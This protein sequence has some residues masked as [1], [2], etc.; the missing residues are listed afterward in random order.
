M[1]AMMTNSTAYSVDRH[2]EAYTIG[3]HRERLQREKAEL[4]QEVSDLIDRMADLQDDFNTDETPTE[5]H[6]RVVEME[7][8]AQQFRAKNTRIS[9]IERDLI[10]TT[11]YRQQKFLNAKKRR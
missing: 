8:I 9:L 4:E 7:K 1:V 2:G 3:K 11:P 5:A 6:H 10:E